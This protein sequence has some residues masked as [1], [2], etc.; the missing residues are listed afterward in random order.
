MKRHLA[1]WGLALLTAAGAAAQ[2][3]L[4]QGIGRPGD[5]KNTIAGAVLD[6]KL[7][8]VEKSGAL[9]VTDPADGAWK[10]L[11]KVEFG[12]TAF[13]FALP[14]RLA[15]IGTDGDLRL[16]DPATGEWTRS[17][18]AGDWKNTIAG[19]VLDGKLYTVEAS[20]ALYVTDAI[21]GTWRKLG[22]SEFAAVRFLFALP[23][24]LAA[25][26]KEGSLHLIAPADGSRRSSGS[27][28]AWPATVAGTAVGARL[29]TVE[30]SGALYV[31]D[32]A[33]GHWTTVS[34]SGFD[35]VRLLFAAGDTLLAIEEDGDLLRIT[36][37]NAQAVA[38][39]PAPAAA[40]AAAA[41]PAP[42][43][44][45]GAAA[46]AGEMTAWFMGTWVGD[47]EPLKKDAEYQKQ[48]A[49]NPQM[50][51][52]LLGMMAGMKMTVTADGIGMEVMGE[53]APPF[54]FT[55]VSAEGSTLTIRNEEGPDKGSKARITFA[56]R[57]HIRMESDQDGNKAMFFK[58]E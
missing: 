39:T 17:G 41:P 1:A 43:A 13:L 55:V 36:P 6:G 42:P 4:K 3:E 21:E 16:V 10:R 54:K 33:S 47:V 31:T 9:Y 27:A 2:E 57:T 53:K 24:G 48:A 51:Q 8:T 34:P 26:D 32:G 56:D 23:D 29:W 15:T 19:A 50:V 5:W 52:A 25:I 28:G 18:R 30:S 44:A 14:D 38:S 49:A 37:P 12:A 40:P 7:Y 58:K 35:G 46:D 22:A 45:A 20:G 11:G